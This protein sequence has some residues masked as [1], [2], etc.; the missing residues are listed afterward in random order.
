MERRQDASDKKCQK[1]MEGRAFGWDGK[2][3]WSPLWKNKQIKLFFFAD[4]LSDHL[5]LFKLCSSADN[6]DRLRDED[7]KL[8]C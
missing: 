6:F 4:S 8:Q 2:Q 3:I 1:Q 7:D 5:H